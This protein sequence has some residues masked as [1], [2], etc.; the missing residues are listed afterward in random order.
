MVKVK[1][2]RRMNDN[3]KKTLCSKGVEI[4]KQKKRI[5]RI[6]QALEILL[7]IREFANDPNASEA[8]Q[9]DPSIND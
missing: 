6:K 3:L 4:A 8:D 2:V 7:I 1:L 5:D 9:A